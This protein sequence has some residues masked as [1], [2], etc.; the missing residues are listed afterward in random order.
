[1]KA[2]E[3]ATQVALVGLVVFS[4]A[5]AGCVKSIEGL[6]PPAPAELVK[7]IYVINHGWHTGIAVQRANI[8]EGVWPE[9]ADF[10]DSEYVEVG[11]GNR[12]F[13]TA[14]K[15]TLGLALKAVIWPTPGV[16]HVVGFDGPVPQFFRQREIVE[17]LVSDRGFQRLAAFIGDGYAK[18]GSGRTTAVGRGQ[19]ANSRFYV[20]REKY[21]LLKTCNT[22]TAR[23]LRSAGLPIT[24]LYAVS[25]GNVMDQARPL[26]RRISERAGEWGDEVRPPGSVRQMKAS[27]RGA[28]PR[29]FDRLQAA[30]RE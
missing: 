20:A 5:A 17:I 30:R 4:A 14:P 11:W 3:V 2:R 28:H 23:A 21:F 9:H 12:E 26:G 19:Y 7:P 6:Y 13:Y 27:G 1:V 8:P 10:A 29:W 16:L 22:W 25:A 18:D 24:S 15:G